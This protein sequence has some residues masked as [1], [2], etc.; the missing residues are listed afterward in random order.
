MPPLHTFEIARLVA[1][2]IAGTATPQE[3]E[4]LEAWLAADTDNRRFF[5]TLSVGDNIDRRI[6]EYLRLDLTG[7]K[8]R[9]MDAIGATGKSS[10]GHKPYY[11]RR[12]VLRTAA[13]VAATAAV[14]AIVVV[15]HTGTVG[16][17]VE[18]AVGT[19]YLETADGRR[20]DLG[21]TEGHA[22]IETGAGTLRADGEGLEYMAE[23]TINDGLRYDRIVIPRG[24]TYRVTLPDGSRVWL[25]AATELRYMASGGRDTR[26]V[27]LSGE[28]YFEV[29]PSGRP[30]VVNTGG[31]AVR[32]LGTSFNVSA[33]PDEPQ[34]SATLVE[35]SV[36]VVALKTGRTALITPGMQA[37]VAGDGRIGLR[38]VDP[39]SSTGWRDDM[40]VFDNESMAAI[41]RK[42][43]R[44]YDVE[45]T[46][47]DE[48]LGGAT[49]YGVMPRHESVTTILDMMKKTYPIDYRITRNGIRIRRTGGIDN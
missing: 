40:F 38:D 15:L 45:I 17:A 11:R 23:D 1:A 32:V 3:D 28:A 4:Q 7:V 6:D 36:E 48:T 21:A 37:S 27:H 10:P 49:F 31:A 8:S 5:D 43:S 35:G 18:P 39:A 26:E 13:V 19:A 16:E 41:M 47:D 22:V 2:R 9:T 42:L 12:N 30:F 20:F 29:T 24:N 33:Y 14:A 46:F 44:W 25:N 34:V